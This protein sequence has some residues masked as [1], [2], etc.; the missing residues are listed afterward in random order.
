[1][2]HSSGNETNQDER[3][4]SSIYETKEPDDVFAAVV[5]R[6][7]KRPARV[8]AVRSRKSGKVVRYLVYSRSPRRG[9]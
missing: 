8:L 4:Q 3:W 7:R 1:M 5:S 2:D 9:E 6:D